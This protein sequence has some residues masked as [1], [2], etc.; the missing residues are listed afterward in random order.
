MRL[1]R[2]LPVMCVVWVVALFAGSAQ[3][4]FGPAAPQQEPP[5]LRDFAQLREDTEKKAVAIRAAS[6]RKASPREACQLFN[7]FVAAQSKMLKYATDNAAWCGIPNQVTA[8]LKEGI[9][10]ASEIRTKVCQAAAAPQRPA[11]PSLSD[12]LSGPVPD[13]NNIKTGRGTFDTLTGNPLEKK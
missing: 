9:T 8:S 4:Q 3:A 7:A 5:C 2:A 1:R 11:G 6:E 10:K 12:A 13:S